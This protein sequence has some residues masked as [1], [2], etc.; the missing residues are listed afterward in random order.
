MAESLLEQLGL[1]KEE[2]EAIPESDVQIYTKDPGVYDVTIDKAFIRKTDSG[3]K[4]LELEFKLADGSD[5]SW[6]TCINS[7]DQK[8]NKSYWVVTENHSEAVRKRNP[9]GTKIPL[10]GVVDFRQFL[11]AIHTPDPGAVEGDVMFKD[12]KISATC[13]TGVQGLKL[14][15]GLNQYEN[16]WNGNVSVKND[17]KYWMDIEGKNAKG[18]EIEESV[19]K[20]LA[21]PSGTKKLR[22][23]NTTTNTSTADSAAAEAQGW[24]S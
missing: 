13:L 21:G 15:I 2:M 22:V 11:D 7:G 12:N 3:A 24:G 10:P 4:M 19:K 18:K 20:T 5:F 14:K 8:G 1:S 23:S 17:I 16:E 9:V 6:S